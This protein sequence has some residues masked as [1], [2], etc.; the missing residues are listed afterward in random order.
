M[1]N[2]IKNNIIVIGII[3]L[4]IIFLLIISIYA[5]TNKPGT[6]SINEFNQK[7]GANT[8]NLLS[9]SKSQKATKYTVTI[10]NNKDEVIKTMDTSNNSIIINDIDIK[11]YEEIKINVTA[12]NK[13]GKKRIVDDEKTY[14]WQLPVAKVEYKKMEI[15]NNEDIK[16]VNIMVLYINDIDNKDYYL[17][18]TK[19]KKDVFTAP[20]NAENVKIS[21]QFF[22][23]L[24]NS[25]GTYEVL[26]C[27]DFKQERTIY[28]K[29]TLEISPTPITDIEIINSLSKVNVPWK[30]LF[31][32]FRGGENAKDYYF[33]LTGDNNDIIIDN[34]LISGHEFYIEGDKLEPNKDYR[35]T[36]TAHHILDFSNIKEVTVN[37]SIADKEKVNEIIT[38]RQSGEI[39]VNRAIRLSTSTEIAKIYY[40][41]DGSDPTEDSIEY[42]GSIFINKDMTIKAIGV[43]DRMYNSDIVELKYEPVKK[44]I[45]I[46]LSPSTQTDNIGIASA[47]YTTEMEMMNKVSNYIEDRLKSKGIIVYRNHPD[48]S[49][50]EIVTDSSRYDVDMHLAIHSNSYDGK[51]R[52]I[53][54]WVHDAS[55]KTAEKIADIIQDSLVSIYYDSKGNRGV[56]YSTALGGMRETNPKNVTNG[57]LVEIAFH[58]H[59]NDAKWIVD[60]QMK[61]G[62]NIADSVA[63]YFGK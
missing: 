12:Y 24:D 13:Q 49:L 1:K 41:T 29:T 47:G 11:P 50:A 26:L 52:G 56:C 58:D 18:I 63:S 44:A 48:M 5:I 4:I 57:V 59:Y 31:V 36:I 22:K 43:A 53:E 16:D 2:I 35:L 46:Y 39:G 6:F 51:N 40:T 33:T 62:Y 38:T 20:A 3:V 61:I 7:I 32:Q 60:N 14:K 54:T 34:A 25:L 37:F 21:S 15:L 17:V 9:W 42:T 23:N 28:S 8:L 55:C 45:A 10:S 27:K 30:D 19:D